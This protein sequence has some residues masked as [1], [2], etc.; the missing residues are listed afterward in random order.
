MKEKWQ[1]F[2]M[3]FFLIIVHPFGHEVIHIFMGWVIPSCK[4]PILHWFVFESE[5]RIA[6]ILTPLAVEVMCSTEWGW[7]LI[8]IMP[9]VFFTISGIIILIIAI[10]KREYYLGLIGF[11]CLSSLIVDLIGLVF[12]GVGDISNCLYIYSLYH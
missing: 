1:I 3:Y 8:G 7:Y 12:M 6:E 9:I 10:K 4:P 2:W 11:I 5:F